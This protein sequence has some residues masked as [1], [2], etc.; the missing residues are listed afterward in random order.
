MRTKSPMRI[1]LS[2][3]RSSQRM[4]MFYCDFCRA[5][6]GW[7]R[8]AGW[9][10]MGISEGPCEMCGQHHVCHDVPSDRLVGR[11]GGKKRLTLKDCA[12][13]GHRR[14]A[15]KDDYLCVFCRGDV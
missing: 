13:C 6:Q 5:A 1:S 15:D 14:Y 8:S 3:F 11:A 9:P 7:P 12:E 2:S 4:T 10:H